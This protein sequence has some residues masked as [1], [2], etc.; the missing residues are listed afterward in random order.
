PR[1]ARVRLC[2]NMET[3]RRIVQRLS[4]PFKESGLR[5]GGDANLVCVHIRL[6]QAET[7]EQRSRVNAVSPKRDDRP[8]RGEAGRRRQQADRA[9]VVHLKAPF[10]ETR[11]NLTADWTPCARRSVASRPPQN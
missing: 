6:G 4:G 10:R 3:K 9:Y 2:A 11:V 5:C 8:S 1:P 7:R